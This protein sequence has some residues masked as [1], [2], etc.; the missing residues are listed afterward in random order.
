MIEPHGIPPRVCPSPRIAA[1]SSSD[2]AVFQHVAFGPDHL[3]LQVLVQERRDGP[4][5]ALFRLGQ[6]ERRLLELLR[7]LP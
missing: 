6:S 2:G 7:L 4:A 5:L 1:S 3:L